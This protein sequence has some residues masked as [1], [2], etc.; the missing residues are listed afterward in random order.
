MQAEE[1]SN[2]EDSVPSKGKTNAEHERPLMEE[3]YARTKGQ[4]D[5]QGFRQSCG[6]SPRQS[7]KETIAS[8]EKS[9]AASPARIPPMV[10]HTLGLSEENHNSDDCTEHLRMGRS[11]TFS[12]QAPQSWIVN[13]RFHAALQ[14]GSAAGSLAQSRRRSRR[15]TRSGRNSRPRIGRTPQIM[16]AGAG[17]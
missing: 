14:E 7:R 16:A 8:Y 13:L 10:E 3:R 6:Q 4:P 1:A 11:R 15:W 2:P 5:H 17:A 9:L 12:A